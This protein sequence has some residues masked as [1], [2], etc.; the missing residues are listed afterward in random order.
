MIMRTLL[1]NMLQVSGALAYNINISLLLFKLV[2]EKI[3]AKVVVDNL[4]SIGAMFREWR[5][6]VSILPYYH[7]ETS[8]FMSNNNNAM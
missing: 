3:L 2:L 4:C 5:L 6:E 7:F 8:H 1:L